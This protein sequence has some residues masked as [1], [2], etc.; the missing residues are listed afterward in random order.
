[1]TQQ[2]EVVIGLEIH[3]EL[4]TASKLF[5]GCSTEFGGSP[6]SHCCPICLGL[7]G[8]LP[9]VNQRALEYAILSGL[10]L[11]CTIARYTKFD[12]KNYFYPDLPKA[13]QI[14]QY[15]QP[16]CGPGSV[17]FT[18]DAK[19]TTVR[20]NRAHLEENAGKTV[21]SGD[22]IVGSVYSS[23]D[24]NRGGIPL[25]EIVTEPDLRSPQ[26]AKEFLEHLKLILQ[27]V[28]VS[29]CKM[30]EGSLRCDA[31]ISLRPMGTADLQPK[32]EVKNLNSFRSVERALEYEVARQSALYEQGETFSQHT[33]AWDEQGGLTVSMR[34]KEEAHDYRYFPEPD[35]P[36]LEI[37]PAW[38]EEIKASLPEL[39]RQR[40]ERLVHQYQL[41]PYDA[42]QLTVS[43]VLA[44]Y[45]EAAVER[46]PQPKTVSNWLLGEFARLLKAAGADLERV[47][48]A[49]QDLAELLQLIDAGKISANQGKVVLAHMFA[50]EKTAAEVV[51]ERGLEQ[52]S[53]EGEL[54]QIVAQVVAANEDSV[55]KYRQGISKV[56]GYLVG[57]VMKETGGKAN[58]AVVNKLLRAAL[59]EE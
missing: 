17:T 38:V 24:Y 33:R 19:E 49:P 36:L 43:R 25:I 54:A 5:C 27:Y 39:P 48:V 21:H 30:E 26:E 12:R 59:D 18:L 46:Y 37:D 47:P 6:N 35:L 58:P 8:T 14:S 42:E 45:F 13:Y 32:V 23:V 2:Y 55:N 4:A 11:D 34:S 10:A 57:Q 29:D 50:E 31:N 22:S 16:I 41:S 28:G 20:I 1:M 56:L 9:V 15:D 3:V 7:P 52:V 40:R 51:K 44:D 53:N